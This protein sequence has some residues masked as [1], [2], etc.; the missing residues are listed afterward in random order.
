MRNWKSIP[1][2][3]AQS[4]ASAKNCDSIKKGRETMAQRTDIQYIRFYTEGSA[5]RKIAPAV[6]LR[7]TIR[8]PKIRKHKKTTFFID[9]IAIAGIVMAA[10]MMILMTVGIAQ[11]VDTR[12]QLQTMTSYVD[13]L[14]Q[15]NTSLKATYA[16]G[17]DLEAVEKT[18]LALGLVPKE[19]VQHIAIRVPAEEITAEPSSWEQFCT[20]LTGLFA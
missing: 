10:V 1:V 8:L 20:F 11:L 13:T 2:P 3:E 12:D 18:A 17:Y 9:P 16:E 7:K 6:D 5:A 15:E 14:Q 4:F 19:Q